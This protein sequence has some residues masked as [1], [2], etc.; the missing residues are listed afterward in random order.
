GISALNR[1]I[2]RTMR[3][4]LLLVPFSSVLLLWAD[5][6]EDILEQQGAGNKETESVRPRADP[7]VLRRAAMNNGGNPK[8]GEANYLSTKCATCHKVHGKGGD[9]GPDLSQIGGKLDRTHLIESI[10]DPSVEIVQGYQA[11]VIQTKSGKV[12][13]GI[14]KS[15][16]AT[17]VAV[18]DAEEK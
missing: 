9:G 14:V 8:R 16:S 3:M 17:A 10:L 6:P 1:Q 18:L 13:T 12:I 11:T 4:G 7:D 5:T 2:H 15:E